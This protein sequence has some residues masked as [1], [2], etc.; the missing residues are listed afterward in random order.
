MVHNTLKR[1]ILSLAITP[2]EMQKEGDLCDRFQA[3]RTPVH[4]AL[5]KLCDAGLV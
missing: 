5:E 1:E 4:A 3:S 2:G